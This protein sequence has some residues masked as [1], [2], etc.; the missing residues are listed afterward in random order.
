MYIVSNETGNVEEVGEFKEEIE[1]VS[2]EG[3]RDED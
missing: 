2:E 3:G 1:R